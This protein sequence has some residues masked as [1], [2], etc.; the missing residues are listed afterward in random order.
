MLIDNRGNRVVV[1]SLDMSK[2]IRTELAAYHARLDE[3]E[4]EDMCDREEMKSTIDPDEGVRYVT[5][6]ELR[7]LMVDLVDPPD[8]PVTPLTGK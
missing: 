6:Y 7:S 2:W 1:D 5:Y 3:G 8:S 4:I